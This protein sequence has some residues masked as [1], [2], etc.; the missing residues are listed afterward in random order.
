M[1]TQWQE[2]YRGV[3]MHTLRLEAA[4]TGYDVLLNKEGECVKVVLEP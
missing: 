2:V 4:P 1:E 3:L